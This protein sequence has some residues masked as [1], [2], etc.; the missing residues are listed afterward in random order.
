MA[1][2]LN[3]LDLVGTADLPDVAVFQPVVGNFDLIAVHDALTEQAVLVADGAA[4]G[5]QLKSGEGV[6]EAGSQTAEAAVAQTGLGLDLKDSVAVDT[7]L[8]QSSGI[9]F[10]VYQIDHI[11]MQG[12]AYKEFCAQIIDL[13]CA[14]ALACAAGRGATLHDLVTHGLGQ[15][16]I[17]LL[18]SCVGDI[19]AVIAQLGDDGSLYLFTGKAF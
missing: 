4:H 10:L 8:V 1:A 9:I 2:E 3:G 18:R 11:I 6:E 17:L 7:Q 12:A 13:L 16:H 14:L 5:G 15:R 19:D